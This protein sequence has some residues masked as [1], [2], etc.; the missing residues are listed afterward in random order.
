MS[1]GTIGPLRA[2][3]MLA[4]RYVDENSSADILA[5]KRSADVGTEVNLG[6]HVT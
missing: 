6:E 5:A 4:H 1:A 2:T 3:T